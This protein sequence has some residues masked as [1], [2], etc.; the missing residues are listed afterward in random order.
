METELNLNRKLCLICQARPAIYWRENK[1][2]VVE[3]GKTGY[4]TI[5]MGRMKLCK[6]CY[7]QVGRELAELKEQGDNLI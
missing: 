7:Y 5:P 1:M 2:I 6:G 4:R 3:G